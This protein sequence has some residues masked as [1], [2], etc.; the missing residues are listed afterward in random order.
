[1]PR[2]N[3][4]LI[5]AIAITIVVSLLAAFIANSIIVNN[6]RLPFE[7]QAERIYNS[8]IEEIESLRGITVPRLP[9]IIIT[10]DQA[11]KLWGG[12]SYTPDFVGIKRDENVYKGLYL[13]KENE[14]L[15]QAQTDWVGAWIAVTWNN[16][17]YVITKYF[18]PYHTTDAESTLVHELTHV[19]QGNQSIPQQAYSTFDA[20]KARGAMNEG[21]AVY[22]QNFF[23]NGNKPPTVNVDFTLAGLWVLQPLNP[24]LN[25]VHASIPSSI[26][27]LNYFPYTY[28][29]NFISQLYSQGGWS[30]V[31][32]IYK[33]PPNT[34]Q[35]IL[36]TDK[37]LE[38][39]NPLTPEAPALNQGGW[40]QVLNNTYGEYFIR[41]MLNTWLPTNESKN[42]A[43]GWNGD[44]LTYYEDSINNFL[45]TWNITWASHDG[46][47]AFTSAFHN[48]LQAAGTTGDTQSTYLTNGRYLTITL[49]G[50]N[51]TLIACSSN[52]TAVE[53]ANFNLQQT[54]I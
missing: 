34:T 30:E 52:R 7:V 46:V 14:S 17:I 33:N 8:A 38:G 35:Q 48:M 24:L 5:T 28:G 22:T 21:D 23:T 41:N 36:H 43:S 16:S 27:N 29:N 39:V 26:S 37:Y 13:M 11:M 2:I 6:K 50:G 54:Y 32:Q 10:E 19:L 20:D 47:I 18:N 44:N 12:G 9:L 40:N 1:M 15:Y 25:S 45:F 51:S 31:N 53:P 42:A 49:N 3:K 4:K